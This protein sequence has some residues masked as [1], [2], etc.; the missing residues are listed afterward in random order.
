MLREIEL[1]KGALVI[2]SMT[3][4]PC[5]RLI[6]KVLKVD[7]DSNF[8]CVY[9][10]TG[11]IVRQ[12]AEQLTPI[13]NF[14]VTAIIEKNTIIVETGGVSTARY[15]NGDARNWQPEDFEAWAIKWN[16]SAGEGEL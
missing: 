5:C 12:P 2:A 15:P 9:L 13:A 10:T 7:S 16:Q 11:D 1:P 6:A 14:G 8:V 4:R 3:D